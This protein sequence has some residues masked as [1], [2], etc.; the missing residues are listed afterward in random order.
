M[1]GSDALVSLA[2]HHVFFFLQTEETIYVTQSRKRLAVE[3]VS[4]DD[5]SVDTALISERSC[6]YLHLH[7]NPS[8]SGV[9]AVF[10]KSY[11]FHLWIQAVSSNSHSG[12]T[13]PYGPGSQ[14]NLINSSSCW[15]YPAW[16]HTKADSNSVNLIRFHCCFCVLGSPSILGALECLF[17]CVSQ[18]QLHKNVAEGTIQTS[19]TFV[20]I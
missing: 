18:E 13:M 7:M 1:K 14:G 5:Y 6:K 2:N 8:I 9:A 10:F 17:T 15:I 16:S 11:V 12:Q 4:Y 3:Y 19:S 20:T